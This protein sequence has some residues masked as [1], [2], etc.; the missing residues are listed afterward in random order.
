MKTLFYMGFILL[1]AP[2]LHA[3]TYSWVDDS[4]TYN[5]T[6][7]YSK[8]PKKYQKKVKRRVDVQPQLSSEPESTPRQAEKTD[9][10]SAAVPVGEKEL[11][12][13]KSRA[14]WRKELGALETELSGVVQH[15][16]QVKRQ[17]SGTNRLTNDQLE[18]L[19]KDYNDSRATYDQKYK[20]YM[21]LVETI[22]KAGIIVEIKK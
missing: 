10:K 21:E 22:R 8:V 9:A 7:D 14:D 2:P 18:I 4:G 11:Y 17:I 5:F 20:N 16:E 15:I 19:K 3:E 13:G 6:E 12:G 1:L